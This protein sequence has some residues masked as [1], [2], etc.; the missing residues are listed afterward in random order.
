[1]FTVINAAKTCTLNKL[2]YQGLTRHP[3]IRTVRSQMVGS[4]VTTTADPENVKAVLSTNFKEFGLGIQYNQF[5]PLFGDGIFTMDGQGWVHSR[6]LL[7]PQFTREQISHV[8]IT[9]EH[10]KKIIE[11]YKANEKLFG[12]KD[13]FVRGVDDEE[14]VERKGDYVD[15]LPLF[16]KLTIDTSTEFLYGES[17]DLLGGGNPNIPQAR[18]FSEAFDKAQLMLTKRALAAKMYWVMDSLEFRRWCK[19]C[20]DFS[21]AYVKLALKRTENMKKNESGLKYIFLDEVAK[22]TRDPIVL[23]DQAMNI[24]LAGRDTT[25]ALLSWTF[26]MLARHKDVFYKL[27]ETIVEEFGDGSDLSN[28]TFETLKRCKYLRYVINETLRIYPLVP[29]NTRMALEDTYIPR[30]GGPNFDQPI[31]I[32]KGSSVQFSIYT[33]HRDPLVWGEDANKFRPERWENMVPP[34][35]SYIPFN[36]GPRICIGQQFALTEASYAIVRLLQSFS[37][38]EGH[39]SILEPEDP[40]EL[41]SILISPKD[42]VFIKLIS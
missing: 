34:T 9:E 22:E 11:M 17:V 32:P 16:F 7:R 30:G 25:A 42:G 37:E 4:F 31:F 20:K 36:G 13:R 27:R 39:S 8:H 18:A 40:V 38:I 3:K 2:L 33:M 5:Y 28:L 14:D 21:M 26:L 35:W 12:K 19:T 29:S 41:A 15:I 23:R 24:M 10:L 6:A 1:M